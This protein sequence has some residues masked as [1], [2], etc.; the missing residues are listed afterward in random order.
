MATHPQKLR[1]EANDARVAEALIGRTLTLEDIAAA[2]GLSPESI[3]KRVFPRLRE[4]GLPVQV[5]DVVSSHG[6]RGAPTACWRIVMPPHR[7]CAHPGCPTLLR[8]TNPAD[9][10]ELH[11]GGFIDIETEY[12]PPS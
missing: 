2:T 10:C 3:R 1:A 4:R 12:E 11:G 6:G 8:S 7:V 9:R 5:V